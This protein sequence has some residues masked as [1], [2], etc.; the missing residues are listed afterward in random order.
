M[1]GFFSY[2]HCENLVG[3]LEIKL[4]KVWGVFLGLGPLSPDF[5]SFKL[6][7]TE[8]KASHQLLGFST[9]E[10][11]GSNGVFCFWASVLGSCNSLYLPVCLSRNR[12]AVVCPVTSIL[13]WIKEELL[14]FSLF[15]I[16]LVVRMGVITSKLLIC[17]P[18]AGQAPCP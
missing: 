9:L 7:Y 17:L 16:F 13:W 2:I 10:L 3:V 15:N 5:S 4:T 1:E 11:T 8:P 18:N 12:R 14:I 6:V